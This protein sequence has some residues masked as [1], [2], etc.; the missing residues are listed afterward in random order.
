MLLLDDRNARL[1]TRRLP[2]RQISYA[3]KYTTWCNLFRNGK[4]YKNKEGVYK[5]LFLI[6]D[7]QHSMLK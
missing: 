5:T 6:R 3:T 4:A 1:E 2:M 7:E